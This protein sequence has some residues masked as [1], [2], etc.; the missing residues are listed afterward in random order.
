[1]QEEAGIALQLSHL[2]ERPL[3]GGQPPAAPTSSSV[4]ER[5][6][7]AVAMKANAML[8]VVIPN[9]NHADYLEGALR[10]VLSQSRPPDEVIVV[11]DCSTDDSVAIVR[12][13]MAEYPTVRLIRNER[14]LGIFGAVEVGT[15]SISSQYIYILSADDIVL[16]GFFE[17]GMSLLRQSPKAG[18]C[19]GRRRLLDP[20]RGE[21]TAPPEPVWSVPRSDYFAPR[22][23]APLVEN[24]LWIA[25]NT[26]ILNRDAFRSVGGFREQLGPYSDWFAYMTVSFRMGACLIPRPVSAFRPLPAGYFLS[27][28]LSERFAFMNA[29][30]ALLDSPA[31]DDVAWLFRR[32]P[33][34][35]EGGWELFYLLIRRPS[36]WKWL[37]TPYLRLCCRRAPSLPLNLFMRIR[38]QYSR[39]LRRRVRSV[40]DRFD[41]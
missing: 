3:G 19:A 22:D 12:G 30:L 35:Y 31:Y 15:A 24:G 9:F 23:L 32:G 41:R 40:I 7:Y 38:D 25:G 2:L 18:L 13:I 33:L 11:D 16:P 17:D 4:L 1:M 36:Y 8:G 27:T 26:A 5:A 29:L 6:I 37:S 14:N 39:P 21:L 10:S 20:N 28:S 34:A